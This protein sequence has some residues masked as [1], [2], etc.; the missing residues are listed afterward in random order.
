MTV[1]I[2]GKARPVK[3]TNNA[4]IEL[5]EEHGIDILNKFDAISPKN[6]RAICFVALKHGAKAANQQIDF[7]LEKVGDWLDMQSLTKEG[8]MGQIFSALR[9]NTQTDQKGEPAGESPGDNLEK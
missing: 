7:D 3:F 2:G 4:L 6:I 1:E 8:A 9:L 5:A